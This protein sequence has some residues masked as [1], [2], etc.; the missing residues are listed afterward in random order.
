MSKKASP[1]LIGIF[2]LAG[3]IIAATGLVLFGAGKYFKNT[4]P[5][6][7]YFDKSAN[8]LQVGSDARFGG[9]RI[10]SVR[11]INVLID[12]VHNRK[13]I[14]VVV[15]LD[16]KELKLISAESGVGIDFSSFEGV[17]K[18]VDEVLRA[19]MIQ[20]SLVTGQL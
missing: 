19:G 10:G 1:T 8:G 4:Y 14:P 5:V 18:E 11:S 15:E 9:V 12:P 2:T 7:L 6:L 3:L 20:Q 17:R 16:E 13:I